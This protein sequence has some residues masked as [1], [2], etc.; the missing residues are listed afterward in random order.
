M[1]RVFVVMNA[2]RITTLVWQHDNA[3]LGVFGNRTNN[4]NIAKARS[5][6]LD[7]ARLPWPL[8]T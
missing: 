6:N 7:N 5:K 3:L 1:V 4:R 2:A 8:S